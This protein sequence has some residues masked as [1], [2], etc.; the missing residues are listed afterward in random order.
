MS[1]SWRDQIY[2][3]LAPERVDFVHFQRGFKA[4]QLSRETIHCVKTEDSASWQNVFAI[5]ENHLANTKGKEL[6]VILS[7]HFVRY[8]T[9]PPQQEITTPEEVKS[10]ALFRMREI[11]SDRIESWELSISDWSPATGAVCAAI[12]RDLMMQLQEM[13]KRLG[14]KLK[15]VEPYLAAVYDHWQK[16]LS[17][18]KVY[19]AVAEPGRICTAIIVDGTWKSIRNQRVLFQNAQ[20]LSEELLVV[21]T[22]EAILYGTK[23]HQATAYVFAPDYPQLT[24]LAL[25]PDSGWALLALPNEQNPAPGYFPSLSVQAA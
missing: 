22:Q 19:L 12:E 18:Q 5:L 3:F 17:G 13:T 25:P 24:Q 2:V 21:L 23:E 7:N 16:Q 20:E 4:A 10:Y 1:L 9:L 11:Y 14:V 6:T 15:A 8:V